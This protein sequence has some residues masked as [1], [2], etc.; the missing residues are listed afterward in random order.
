MT[1]S[2]SVARTASSGRR[3]AFQAGAIHLAKMFTYG[4]VT[5]GGLI[6]GYLPVILFHAG[7]LGIAS[8]VGGTIGGFLGLWVGYRAF[9]YLGL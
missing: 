6:G 5:L 8:I 2:L 7:S 3:A 9:Q 1:D 4:G